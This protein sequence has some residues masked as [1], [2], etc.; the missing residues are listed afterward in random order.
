M[1]LR[2]PVLTSH[3]KLKS[4]PTVNECSPNTG[5]TFSDTEIF[6]QLS[7]EPLNPSISCAAGSP[8]K[9]LAS[10]EKALDSPAN[11]ADS[12]SSTPKR[13]KPFDR[14][15]SLSKMSAPFALA[16][17]I[18]CSGRSLRSGMMRNG[19]AYPLAPL[20]PLTGVIGS[21][22]LPTP[23]ATEYKGGH[24]SKGGL[25]LGMM[26]THNLWPT[27]T[28]RDHFPPHTA[29]YIAAKKAQG[30]GMSNLNDRV[31][32][33]LNPNWVELLMG[34]PVGWTDLPED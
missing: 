24:S 19:I 12:G 3:G 23:K 8:V 17:W 33:S 30:H 32:G 14:A 9:T 15:T 11:A 6:A 28:A 20:V 25:S 10:P 4:I 5:P 7:G 22:L 13:S 18:E 21:G 34:Y 27:P 1:A 26:A 2:E 29:E 16:D 31:G